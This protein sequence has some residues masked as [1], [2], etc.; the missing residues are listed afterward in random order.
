MLSQQRMHNDAD[1]WHT[2]QQV[3]RACEEAKRDRVMA[4]VPLKKKVANNE[5][6]IKEMMLIISFILNDR[7]PLI[8]RDLLI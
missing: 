8:H 3:E 1:R 2:D 6:A 4:C 5:L 7:I